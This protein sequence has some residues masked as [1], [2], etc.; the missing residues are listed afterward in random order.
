MLAHNNI[1]TNELRQNIQIL[2][3]SNNNNNNIPNVIGLGRVK[4]RQ[5]LSLSCPGREVVSN[6]P[7]IKEKHKQN[8]GNT[9]SKNN[10]IV[11]KL[12]HRRQQVVVE[13]RNTTIIRISKLILNSNDSA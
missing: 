3:D 8:Y 2:V 4:C 12:K 9:S 5:I 6:R 1:L 7:S 10:R 11:R 13:M